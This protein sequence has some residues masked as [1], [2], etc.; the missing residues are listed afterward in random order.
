M[1][2]FT[3]I[4]ELKKIAYEQYTSY[5]NRQ[6]YGKKIISTIMGA[7]L[8][9]RE[10]F[11]K[12]R[13]LYD[14]ANTLQDNSK[15]KYLMS[16]LVEVYKSE[17]SMADS[18]FCDE[19]ILSLK[20]KIETSYLNFTINYL[21]NNIVKKRVNNS[22]I[23]T[24]QDA[25]ALLHERNPKIAKRYLSILNKDQGQ[26][27]IQR[28]VSE[29]LKIPDDEFSDRHSVL[30]KSTLLSNQ[31]YFRSHS[32]NEAFILSQLKY[33]FDRLFSHYKQQ[34]ERE[35]SKDNPSLAKL[36]TITGYFEELYRP[37]RSF[38]PSERYKDFIKLKKNYS[39]YLDFFQEQYNELKKMYNYL[40]LPR[41]KINT[42]K[43][44]KLINSAYKFKDMEKKVYHEFRELDPGIDEIIESLEKSLDNYYKEDLL[45]YYKLYNNIINADENDLKIS[46]MIN[47]IQFMEDEKDKHKKSSFILSKIQTLHDSTRERLF[48]ILNQQLVQ[49]ISKTKDIEKI[50][51]AFDYI[52]DRYVNL[53]SID[54]IEFLQNE[55]LTLLDSIKE[56]E[57]IKSYIRDTFRKYTNEKNNNHLTLSLLD[58]ISSFIKIREVLTRYD[59]NDIS[60][61]TE[62][63]DNIKKALELNTNLSEKRLV[64]F[65]KY[66]SLNYIVFAQSKISIG[67]SKNNDIILNIDSISG[68]HCYLD[69]AA[70]N[71]VDLTSTN[72]TYAD[73]SI[74][75]FSTVNISE[76]E[77]F[78]LA[79]TVFFDLTKNQKFFSFKI[80]DV[81]LEKIASDHISADYI[82]SLLN[83]VFVHLSENSVIQLDTGSGKLCTGDCA[84][85]IEIKNLNSQFYLSDP[86]QNLKDR[87][88]NYNNE[89]LSDRFSFYLS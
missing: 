2:N 87:L 5:K 49:T 51:K 19:S 34:H 77:S 11:K 39:D 72:G 18:K 9:N 69:F 8:N 27:E 88:L 44:I 23:T 84:D 41:E 28:K 6:D 58:G 16:S 47:F 36:I 59:Y 70:G 80:S 66:S 13:D 1:L 26:S 76:I 15:C 71:I 14:Y 46:E 30:I 20:E 4:S 74:S 12:A 50:K 78:N 85:Y 25:I 61:F 65:D 48:T 89:K 21:E 24:L 57:K 60:S 43:I 75:P 86:D 83:T 79:R 67:R 53:S 64:I 81:N 40:S 17:F 32:N 3:K 62:Y 22:S 7:S 68:N 45:Y 55:K 31:K 33:K 52:I 56:Y 42:S 54:S 63:V 35:D 82:G 37:V 29:L 73:Q 38:I 10:W